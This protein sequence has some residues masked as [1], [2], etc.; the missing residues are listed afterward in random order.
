MILI[1]IFLAQNAE[2]EFVIWKV[3]EETLWK[4]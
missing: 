3:H 1:Y 2:H 4:L